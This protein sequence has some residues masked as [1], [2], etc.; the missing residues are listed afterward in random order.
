LVKGSRIRVLIHHTKN[1]GDLAVAKAIADLVY[2]EYSVLTPVV[3]EHSPFDLVVYKDAKFY[4]IQAK[5]NADG[6]VKNRTSWTDK[7]GSH[8][9]KYKPDDFD[10]YALYLPDIDK[11]VYPSIKFGGCCITTELPLSP[12]PFYWW[13][14]F[15]DFTDDAKKRTY[16]EF[17]VD[18]TT[19]K[20]NPES[21]IHTR[22]VERPSK[23]ELEKMVWA[24]PT[25]QI[26]R[27][28]GVSDKAVEKWCK[29]YGIEKPPRG[30]WIKLAHS[31]TESS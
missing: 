15:I 13:E 9:K 22:K 10:Y 25:A 7:N 17:G 26:A 30:Y 16:K 4:R 2:K 23:E 6:V 18:L 11:V 1:K 12:T 8:E 24:K 27:D 21:R 31:T 3:C 19:R 28:F 5:Y 29:T 20:V 14:D